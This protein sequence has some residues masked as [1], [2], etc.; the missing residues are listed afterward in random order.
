VLYFIAPT[1]HSLKPVDIMVLKKLG[2]IVNV[3]PVIGKADSLTKQERLD[4]KA[5]I[6]E[7]FKFHQIHIF[8][9]PIL[10]DELDFDLTERKLNQQFRESLPFALVGSEYVEQING[11]VTRVRRHRWGT[12]NVDDPEHSEFGIMRDFLIR[13]HLHALIESTASVHYE[14]FRTKQ[15]MALKEASK[16]QQG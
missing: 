7:E 16:A 12:I 2:E 4:F 11:V 10:D 1:G 15:L 8:P 5:R 3:V 14:H 6:Q 9:D 13:S